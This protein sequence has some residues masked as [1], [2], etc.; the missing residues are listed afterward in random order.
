MYQSFQAKNFR[1]FRDLVI[2]TLERVNLIVGK[3]N[4]GK[5]ALLEA[6]FIHC[7]A[8]NPELT[9]RINAFRGIES[10]TIELVPWAEMPWDS[11]FHDF[12]I[13]ESI[14][15]VGENETTGLRHVRLKA[16]REPEEL[17]KI[18]Q[19]IQHGPDRSKSVSLSSEAIRVLELEYQG[20]N[21]EGRHYMIVD[22]QGIRMEPIPPLPPF[23]AIF[24]PARA[25]TPAREDAQRF[26]KLEALGQEEAVLQALQAVEP[27]LRRI[28]VGVSGDVP[29]LQGDIG[30]T[31]R[32]LIPLPLMGE[33]MAR[34][35]SLVLAIGNARN[36]VVLVD[37]ID[38]GLY[39]SVL[40]DVWQAIGK[41]ARQ[42]NTQ[43]FATTHSLEC[44]VA[45]HKAF[46][47]SEKYDFR[48][49]RLERDEEMISVT[50]YDQ[51]ALEAAIE[52]NLEVR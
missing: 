14:E 42:F 10:T 31:R 5:T 9:L 46:S 51:E 12:N 2:S 36:G 22:Q 15:L 39:Y 48:L 21:G 6:L 34:L 26:G 28:A 41:V 30:L 24:L 1:C 33:G 17:G 40:P 44:I 43:I 8:Y 16:V 49:H 27:R 23:P 20:K 25:R 13:S 50:T 29:I 11:L 37:E 32:Q 18:R 7:G 45:A 35:A 19:F 38:N 4:V 47:K 3:N 52:T